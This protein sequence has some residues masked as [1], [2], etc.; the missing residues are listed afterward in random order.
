MPIGKAFDLFDDNPEEA[1]LA[2]RIILTYGQMEFLLA[3]CVSHTT[4]DPTSAFRIFYRI[5]GETARIEIADALIQPW[6]Q[7]KELAGHYGLVIG[8]LR[9]CVQ[10][11]NQFAHCG[12][13]TDE[14]THTGTGLFFVNFSDP[15]EAPLGFKLN[16][17]WRHIDVPLL[18]EQL[19]YFGYVI[20]GLLYLSRA[21]G[22][23]GT[24][25][26]NPFPAPKARRP[27][28]RY[29]SPDLHIP[30]WLDE[31]QK[32][33]YLELAGAPKSA[34]HSRKSKSKPPQVSKRQRRQQRIAQ[35]TKK[36]KTS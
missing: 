19:D 21:F 24:K 28:R 5:I 14:A 6:V 11:R 26:P 31:D 4:P 18:I 17:A 29:N 2:G 15:A 20:A 23:T 12:W 16:M 30:P 27:P 33:Q 10:I 3:G 22:W 32:R 35:A 13:R 9:E 1:S 7:D 34:S 25:E 8:A 36:M